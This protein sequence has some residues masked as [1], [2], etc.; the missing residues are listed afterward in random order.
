MKIKGVFLAAV[1]TLILFT[2]GSVLAGTY[3]GGDGTSTTPYRISTVDD[4]YELIAS[5][6]DWN[7]QFILTEDLDFEG[8]ALSP[9]G[10]DPITYPFIGSFNGQGY[11][12]RNAVINKPIIQ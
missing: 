1:L 12:L 10:L 8:T 11:V 2:S 3:S 6:W 9:V 4:W 7:Q 5:Y